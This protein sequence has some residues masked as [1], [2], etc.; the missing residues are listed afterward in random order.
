MNVRKFVSKAQQLTRTTKIVELKQNHRLYVLIYFVEYL[1]YSKIQKLFIYSQKIE[2]TIVFKSQ[3]I[4]AK[5]SKQNYFYIILAD[6]T[7][8]IRVFFY[9]DFYTKFFNEI[10]VRK[11]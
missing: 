2:G 10:K 11:L 1:F 9:Q 5:S 3:T 6:N 7:G 4:N 8:T